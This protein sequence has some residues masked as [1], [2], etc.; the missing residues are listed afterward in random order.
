MV[1]G[2]QTRV[3]LNGWYTLSTVVCATV[4]VVAV[5]LALVLPASDAAL[6][7]KVALLLPTGMV[8]VAGTVTLE[9]LLANFTD[10][11][12]PEAALLSVTEH[13]LELPCAML[14]GM[15][16]TDATLAEVSTV[17]GNV[18]VA[19]FI[20][21]VNMAV[22]SLTGVPAVAEKATLLDPPDTRTLAGTVTAG[23]LLVRLTVKPPLGAVPVRVTVQLA[24]DVVA[25][26]PGVQLRL[27]SDALP[28]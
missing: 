27:A 22:R 13:V 24:E 20:D 25:M 4:V 7:V 21:A 17:R 8:T 26:A 19:P 11:P 2:V 15:Q 12:A 5:M 18:V 9:L 28:A 10:T 6:A 16:L 14:A 23:L 3:P 1:V